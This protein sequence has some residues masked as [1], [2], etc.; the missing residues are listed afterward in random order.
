[1]RTRESTTSAVS[2]WAD[3]SSSRSSIWRTDVAADDVAR[4]S[5]ASPAARSAAAAPR[6]S[7]R[8]RPRPT[9]R[10][11]GPARPWPAGC[12]STCERHAQRR[13][14]GRQAAR[15]RCLGG[16]RRR[17][18]PRSGRAVG[19]LRA[20]GARRG[21]RGQDGAHPPSVHAGRPAGRATG[22]STRPAFP[23][24]GEDSGGRGD[25]RRSTGRTEGRRP[26]VPGVPAGVVPSGAGSAGGGGTQRMIGSAA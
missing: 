10:G 18:A 11:C 6:G 20:A 26:P 17:A 12:P 15:R 16:A 24:A 2:T 22:G 21:A 25:R 3:A 1:M 5:P 23:R 8:T 14:P 4:G 19:C 9:A 13:R 7:A